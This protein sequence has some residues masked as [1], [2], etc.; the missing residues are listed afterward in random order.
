MSLNSVHAPYAAEYFEIQTEMT[1]LE[2]LAY[3]SGGS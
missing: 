1:T 3:K 2:A